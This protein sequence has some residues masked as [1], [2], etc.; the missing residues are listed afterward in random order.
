MSATKLVVNVDGGARGNPGPAA[1]GVVV[2]TAAGDLLAEVGETIG[3]AT[4][5]VAEYKA[6]L[7]GIELAI[8]HDGDEVQFFGD[9]ELIVKQVRGEYRVK[10]PGLKPLHAQV[11]SGLASLRSWSIS[12]VRREQNARADALVNDAL[13]AA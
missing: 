13:D 10:D 12:H 6:L 11:K 7:R 9:S 4:N 2:A 1:V 3:P 8:E 5:N